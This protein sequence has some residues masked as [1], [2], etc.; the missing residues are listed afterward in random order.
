MRIFG[1]VLK[2]FFPSSSLWVLGERYLKG[3]SPP[4]PCQYTPAVFTVR[5]VCF[6]SPHFCYNLRWGSDSCLGEIFLFLGAFGVW[7]WRGLAPVVY[8]W[9]TAFGRGTPLPVIFS[10]SHFLFFYIFPPSAFNGTS[11]ECW[12]SLHKRRRGLG[13]PRYWE[14]GE[15][16]VLHN[17][18]CTLSV[19]LSVCPLTR[20]GRGKRGMKQLISHSSLFL[21]LWLIG[22]N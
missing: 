16:Y 4:L 11:L 21:K 5:S 9:R 1:R 19:C 14:T 7:G 20:R 17:T 18:F 2:V 13:W 12:P 8:G 6:Y 15:P 3:L 10:S 22:C